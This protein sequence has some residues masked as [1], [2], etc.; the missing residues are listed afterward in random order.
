MAEEVKEDI[1]I[2]PQ[3]APDVI[4]TDSQTGTIEELKE[5]SVDASDIID[6][7]LDSRNGL[8]RFLNWEHKKDENGNEYLE[9]FTKDNKKITLV[10][11]EPP[12][13]PKQ[14]KVIIEDVPIEVITVET[15]PEP[16]NPNP[17]R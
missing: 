11:D 7:P 3:P 13:P 4:L 12:P 1:I 16:I 15:E 8:H 6:D 9:A 14:Y 2:D 5:V 10:V 17:K